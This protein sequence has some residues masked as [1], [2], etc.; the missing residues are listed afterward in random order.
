MKNKIIL[1][2]FLA[3]WTFISGCQEDTKSFYMEDTLGVEFKKECTKTECNIS[4]NETCGKNSIDEN[5]TAL[6]G[7]RYINGCVG[8]N[9]SVNDA[10]CRLLVCSDDEDCT[11]IFKDYRCNSDGLCESTDE[12]FPV[13]VLDIIA[14]CLADI[15][16]DAQDCYPEADVNYIDHVNDLIHTACPDAKTTSDVCDY[17]PD[18]CMDKIQNLN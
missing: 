13:L 9:Y 12:N 15:K 2:L 11:N 17:M 1:T 3:V 6:N 16:R 5:S 4:N 14:M 7:G 8:A 10:Q 18:E